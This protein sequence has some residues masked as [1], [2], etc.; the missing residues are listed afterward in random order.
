[1][2][3]RVSEHSAPLLLSPLV[4]SRPV[5]MSQPSNT[6]IT[7]NPLYYLEGTLGWEAAGLSLSGDQRSGSN[8]LANAAGK[9]QTSLRRT[10]I[11]A[12]AKK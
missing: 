4:Y 12:E 5:P 3:L 2:A 1:M 9:V 10:G 7:S 11:A 6:S 8:V